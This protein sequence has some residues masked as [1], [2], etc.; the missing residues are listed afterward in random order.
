MD[1]SYTVALLNGLRDLVR[2]LSKGTEHRTLLLISDGFQLS[3][4]RDA[5]AML[6]AYHF[7]SREPTPTRLTS[8]FEAVVK[9]AARSNI[10]I[11]T[12]DSRGLY[13]AS[14]TDASTTGPSNSVA[15]DVMSTMNTLQAEA[16][17]TLTEFSAATGGKSYQNTNDLVAGIRKAVAD[18]RNF[19]TLGYVSTNAA[20]DGKFRNI[21]VEV[22]GHKL[23]L[24][25]KRGYWA[26]A[27]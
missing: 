7:P 22:K 23:T 3:P 20:M 2:E 21:T 8:E 12:I 25:A 9:V 6:A 19:Y 11:N 14:W 5:W 10:I 26:T 1:R 4:G 15:V 17:M 16:G 27:N 18:G 13:S 24:R